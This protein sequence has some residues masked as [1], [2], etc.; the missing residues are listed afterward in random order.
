MLLSNQ[1]LLFF[2]YITNFEFPFW[3]IKA[4]VLAAVCIGGCIRYST[5]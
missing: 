5:L 1:S 2:N 4:V 3:G